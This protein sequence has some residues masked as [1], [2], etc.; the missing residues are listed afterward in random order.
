M[1][2]VE[3]IVAERIREPIQWKEDFGLFRGSAFGLAHSLNQLSIFRARL[4]HPFL[5]NLYRVGASTRPGNG[6]PLVMIG[7]RLT[8]EAVLSD[9]HLDNPPKGPI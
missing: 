3:S 2:V 8:A 9:N 7:A 4:R 5:K 6:V 1:R